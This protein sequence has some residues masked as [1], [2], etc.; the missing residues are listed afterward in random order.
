MPVKEVVINKKPKGERRLGIPTIIDRIAQQ[1]VKAHLERILEHKFH[2][3]SF[4]YRPGESCHQAVLQAERNTFN[5]DFVIDL[6][7]KSFFDTI[8]QELL[9]KSL[10]HYCKDKWVLMYVERWLKAGIVQ[11]EGNYI[12]RVTGTSQGGVI[13]PLLANLFL[14]VAFDKWMDKFHPEKPFERYADDIV[15]HCKT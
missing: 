11:K 10:T 8:D 3:S 6:D 7:I 2:N 9:M 12:D 15:I 5:H 4:G 1:V 13:S 14:H